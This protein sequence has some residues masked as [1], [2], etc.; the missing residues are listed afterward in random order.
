MTNWHSRLTSAKKAHQLRGW[1]EPH[2]Y[3]G[4]ARTSVSKD[5]IDPTKVVRAAPQ[6]A[7]SIER[8]AG[9]SPQQAERRQTVESSCPIYLRPKIGLGVLRFQVRP[10][11]R[12]GLSSPSLQVFFSVGRCWYQ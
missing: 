1:G 5:I 8:T 3:C 6:N 11:A 12:S 2:S 9:D 10:L 4:P 7:A